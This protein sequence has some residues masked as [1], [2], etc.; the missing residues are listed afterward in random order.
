MYQGLHNPQWN[1]VIV[2]HCCTLLYNAPCIS[3]IPQWHFF[4]LPKWFRT[5]SLCPVLGNF[6]LI[7]LSMDSF[8]HCAS[9]SIDPFNL[10]IHICQFKNFLELLKRIF[11]LLFLCS[12]FLELQL[13]FSCQTAWIDLILCLLSDFLSLWVFCSTLCGVASTSSSLLLLVF[14][15]LHFVEI[16]L[17]VKIMCYFLKILFISRIKCL[18]HLEIVMIATFPSL[19][20]LV[21]YDSLMLDVLG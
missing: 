20:F 13:L 3:L 14:K 5:I 11:S 6:I 18:R 10:E 15:I 8:I 2:V 4:S 21:C 12:F 19:N 16:I 1:L 7:V 9:H 17:K